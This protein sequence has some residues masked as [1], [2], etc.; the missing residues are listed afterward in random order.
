MFGAIEAKGWDK[1]RLMKDI[2]NCWIRPMLAK[3]ECP[4]I[5][6]VN[7]GILLTNLRKRLYQKCVGCKQFLVELSAFIN[8]QEGMDIFPQILGKKISQE[9]ISRLKE[10]EW[11]LKA[12]SE[13]FNTFSNSQDQRDIYHSLLTILAAEEG[14]GFNKAILLLV[15]Q[16]QGALKATWGMEHLGENGGKVLSHLKEYE[17]LEQGTYRLA[18]IIE[19]LIF[20]LDK[21]HPVTGI[22]LS[23]EIQHVDGSVQDPVLERI[24][25][26]LSTE[27]CIFLPLWGKK[28]PLGMVLLDNGDRE[29]AQSDLRAIASFVSKASLAMERVH[30][31][32]RVGDLMREKA[33]AD[34]YQYA[35]K[36]AEIKIEKVEAVNQLTSKIAHEI[37][38]PVTA[39][40]GLARYLLSKMDH[41]PH[42]EIVEA[43]A[44]EAEKLETLVNQVHTLAEDL[45]PSKGHFDLVRVVKRTIPHLQ[46][47]LPE[48]YNV[49]EYLPDEVLMVNVDPKHIKTVL[50]HLVENGIEAMPR[51]GTVTVSLFKEG[52]EAVIVVE[53]Q[54]EGI[55]ESIL[56]QVE[57]PFFTTK[58][59]GTGLG[60]AICR[61]LIDENSGTLTLEST[62]GIGTKAVI[63]LPLLS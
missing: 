55:P 51:G 37:R 42:R 4:N 6:A 36:R 53:D 56:K 50:C 43:I 45:Y 52:D 26:L 32:Q 18:P 28:G 2:E 29:L 14:F 40:G 24:L 62:V 13:V 44:K 47:D 15:N 17:L 38:N 54:G 61:R 23:R 12:F 31:Y 3:G 30:L 21:N 9:I 35:E 57:E 10:Q 33:K 48:G 19:K 39:I 34:A 59:D 16:L 58:E 25:R 5:D 41:H 49:V 22:M 8:P 1:G 7:E 20:P 46:S 27:S 63:R 60:L 11:S